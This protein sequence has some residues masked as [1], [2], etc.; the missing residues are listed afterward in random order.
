[1]TMK[2]LIQS[3]T[4]LQEP[5][6]LF[7]ATVWLTESNSVGQ[8]MFTPCAHLNENHVWCI[9]SLLVGLV[10]I[11]FLTSSKSPMGT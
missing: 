10:R 9:V 3:T 8:I 4:L 6:A 2:Y 1:M 5:E 7:M 11:L